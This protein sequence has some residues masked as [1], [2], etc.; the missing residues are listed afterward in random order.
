[1]AS[2]LVLKPLAMADGKAVPLILRLVTPPLTGVELKQGSRLLPF[3]ATAVR[4]A[5]LATYRDSPLTG[6]ASGSAIEAFLLHARKSNNG[7]REVT[8]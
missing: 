1:M 4:D 6:A 2:P 8:R 5:R 3:P 7:F